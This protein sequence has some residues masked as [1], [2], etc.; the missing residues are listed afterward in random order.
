MLLAGPPS[1]LV[2]LLAF[3]PGTP[4]VPQFSGTALADDDDGGDDDDDDG[5]GGGGGSG[6][7]GTGGGGSLSSDD[8][9]DGQPAAKPKAKPQPK[10]KPR[11]KP[12]PKAKPVAKAERG[13]APPRAPR[14]APPPTPVLLDASA[15]NEVVAL[16]LDGAATL[17]LEAQGYRVLQRDSIE[18]LAASLVRLAIPGGRSIAEAR[19]DIAAVGASAQAEPNHFYRTQAGSV[20][21]TRSGPAACDGVQCSAFAQISWPAGAP[22]SCAAEVAVGMVDT[23]VNE[24]HEVFRGRD[25]AVLSL[26][27]PDTGNSGASHGTAV[28]SILIGDAAGRVPGL[29]P[30]A[31]LIAVDVFHRTGGDERADAFAIIR[32]L[33][34]LAG[35]GARIINLSLAGPDN[36]LMQRVVGAVAARGIRIVAAAGNNGP[37]AKPAYP[38]AYREVIAVTA[39]DTAGAVYRRANQGPHIDIAAPGVDVWTAASVRG[40]RQRTGTSFAAPFVTA[41]LAVGPDAAGPASADTLLARARDLGDPG[42]DPVFGVG[43]LQA[44]PGCGP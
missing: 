40:I 22:A 39:V 7:G 27:M 28:A 26:A 18:V 29:I 3:M 30:D 5:G 13:V 11:A 19:A 20:T 15:E 16:G 42:T 6:G 14:P 12:K 9:G 44:P 37:S 10:A 33:D 38:A 21:G 31:R 23:G 25:L 8:R 17:A 41:A 43:L 35:M 34:M 24:A 2:T 32:A 1:A 4:D 36:A